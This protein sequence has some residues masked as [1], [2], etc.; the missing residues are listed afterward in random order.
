MALV[1][2]QLVD[3]TVVLAQIIP[4]AT[5]VPHDAVNTGPDGQFVYVVTDGVAEKRRSSCCSTTAPMM[6][7]GRRA[8]RA[9]R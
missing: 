8:N 6:R 1:P 5:L 7:S 4:G 2:G 9:T 3:N